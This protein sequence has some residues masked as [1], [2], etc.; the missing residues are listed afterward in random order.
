MSM[1]VPVFMVDKNRKG[2]NKFI[3]DVKADLRATIEFLYK[4]KM[5][6]KFHYEKWLAAL[7]EM[8]DEVLL[9]GWWDDIVNSSMYEVDYEDLLEMQDGLAGMMKGHE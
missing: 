4:R 7:D 2:K 6:S 5:W 8:T 1:H 9:H 3:A